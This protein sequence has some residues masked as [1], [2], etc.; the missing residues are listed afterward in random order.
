MFV[1]GDLCL[2][3]KN[4]SCSTPS[5]TEIWDPPSY[6]GSRVITHYQVGRTRWRRSPF[7]T[8][9]KRAAETRTKQNPVSKG[10]IFLHFPRTAIKQMMIMMSVIDG[11]MVDKYPE[12]NTLRPKWCPRKVGLVDQRRSNKM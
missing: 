4:Q 7:P 1:T 5:S 8:R 11:Y 10:S 6:V 2:R 9:Q 3:L 12:I